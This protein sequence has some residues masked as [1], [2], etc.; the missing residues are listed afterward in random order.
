M[1]NL[2]LYLKMTI[3]AHEIFRGS[4]VE[5]QQ[6]FLKFILENLTLSGK[7]LS[8]SWQEPYNLIFEHASC[9]QW[10]P[11]AYETRTRIILEKPYIY[12]TKAA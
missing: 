3:R 5:E 12:Y 11:V 1:M 8:I 4:Q 7:K 6:E 2:N 10:L 9:S